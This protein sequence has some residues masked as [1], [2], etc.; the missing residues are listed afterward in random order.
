MRTTLT[1]S[2]QLMA[3]A[4]RDAHRLR[5]SFKDVVNQA[6]ALGLD[7]LE[8]TG[9][10]KPYQ[11]KPTPMGLRKGLNYDNISELLAQSEAEDYK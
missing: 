8:K 4:K 7:E 3:R 2:D 10:G 11:T 9:R 6:I 1:L 5:R